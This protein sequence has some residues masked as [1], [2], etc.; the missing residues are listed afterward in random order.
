MPCI[1]RLHF[2]ALAVLTLC[3][4]SV[5]S[6][7]STY[8]ITDLGTLGGSTSFGNGIKHLKLTGKENSICVTFV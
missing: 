7:Q 2:L 5:G 3:L 8:T 6:A 4:V 1:S